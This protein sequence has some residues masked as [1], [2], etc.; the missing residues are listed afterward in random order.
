[1]RNRSKWS[2]HDGSCHQNRSI[3]MECGHTAQLRAQRGRTTNPHT[4]NEV[5]DAIL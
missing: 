4:V 1:M 3:N 5:S 2:K